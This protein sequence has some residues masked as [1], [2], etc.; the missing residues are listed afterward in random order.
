MFEMITPEQAGISSKHVADFISFCERRSIT[1]HSVLMIKGDKI[2]SEN[3]WA[4]FHKD[5]CHRMYSQTKSY[6]GVAIGLLEEEGKLNLDDPMAKYFPERIDRELPHYLAEQTVREMLTMTTCGHPARWFSAGDPDRTHLYFATSDSSR[7]AGTYFEY[8]SPGSQVLCSLVEKLAGKSLFDYLNEKIFSELGTFKTATILK[9]PCG[10]SWGDSALVCTSRDMA[11]FARFVMNYGTWN[12]KRLMNEAYLRKATTKQVGNQRTGFDLYESN[13]YG[14]QIWMTEQGG[15]SFNGMGGQFTVCVPEK[16][17]IFV[18]TGD[19]QGY[20]GFGQ[21]LFSALFDKIVNNLGDAPLEEDVPSY[22][23]LCEATKNLK[24]RSMK[25][26]TYSPLME[27]IHGREYQCASNPMG[28]TRFSMNFY[29]DKPCEFRYTNGQGDKVL[30]FKLGENAF[31][32]FPQLGYSNEVGGQRTTDGFLYNCAASAAWDDATRLKLYV[33]VV[34]RYFGTLYMLFAF[35]GD[36]VAVNMTKTA[37]D[38]F[39][40]YA[41]NLVGKLAD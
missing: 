34:D 30:Y 37:E 22:K 2:F 21:V 41:G 39:G 38:F 7:P 13:G 6:V 27:T 20:T 31:G 9:T 14:Y 3:Y 33:Q 29:Q 10:D 12:G 16:D 15:F 40:E 26:D 28:I 18:C 32:K 1:M 8:D 35:K 24:L 11:S 23:A 5:F 25:G 4:P 36:E 17:F 19:N